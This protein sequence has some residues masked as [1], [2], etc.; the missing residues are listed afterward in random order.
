MRVHLWKSEVSCLR[1]ALA[2]KQMVHF[3]ETE[4]PVI[5]LMLQPQIHHPLVFNS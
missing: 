2:A 5:P 1:L 3:E 4:P